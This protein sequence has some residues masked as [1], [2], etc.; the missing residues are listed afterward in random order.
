[1]GDDM[2]ATLVRCE[3]VTRTFGTGDVQVRALRGLDL[4]VAAGESVALVGRPA[5]GKSTLLRILAGLDRPTEGVV[6]VAGHDLTS[7]RRQA[8]S[9]HLRRTVGILWREPTRNLLPYL[10]A[11]ENVAV[12]MMLS[13]WRGR[14]RRQDRVRELLELV[15]VGQCRERRPDELTRSEQQRVAIATALANSPELL[16]ADE[17]AGQL[18]RAEA[19]EALAAVEHAATVLD[20]TVIIASRDPSVAEHAQRVI[21][22]QDG[23]VHDGS[24]TSADS[25]DPAVQR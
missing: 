24:T 9:R 6:M 4:T 3:A 15:K 10:T 12:P 13:G 21:S 1:M 2:T 14:R 23:R 20:V 22:I 7:M 17:P 19:H 18:N 16:L 5:S 8:R 25:G 11:Q